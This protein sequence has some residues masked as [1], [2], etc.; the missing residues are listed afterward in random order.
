MT[1]T[2]TGHTDARTQLVD[3]VYHKRKPVKDENG[4]VVGVREAHHTPRRPDGS[5]YGGGRNTVY[6]KSWK[7]PK[8]RLAPEQVAEYHGEQVIALHEKKE[9]KAPAVRYDKKGVNGVQLIKRTK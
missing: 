9:R 8:N 1:H 7:A 2:W 5:L 4:K 6:S 3:Y